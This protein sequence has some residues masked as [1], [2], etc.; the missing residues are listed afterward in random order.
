MSTRKSRLIAEAAKAGMP[1][2]AF[3]PGPKFFS[4]Y[5]I[6]AGL[7]TVSR[8]PIINSDY[9]TYKYTPV[10]A[11]AMSMKGVLYTEIDLT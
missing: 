3:S 7:L 11:D 1:Y 4:T 8:Y 6:D 10:G 5:C 2:H 9:T